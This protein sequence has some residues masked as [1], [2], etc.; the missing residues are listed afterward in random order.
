MLPT[1][2]SYQVMMAVMFNHTASPRI[3]KPGYQKLSNC[4]GTDWKGDFHEKPAAWLMAARRGYD[5]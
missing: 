2:V 5:R 4:N 1:I 3:A